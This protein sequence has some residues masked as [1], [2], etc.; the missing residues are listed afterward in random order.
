MITVQARAGRSLALE[1]YG[2]P[3]G[4]PVMWFHGIPSSRVGAR[5]LHQQALSRDVAL[6]VPDRPGYG[7]SDPDP[8]RRV[9]DWP[10]DVCT[11]ADALQLQR[12]S[13][14]GVSG[15]FQ[16]VLATA[17]A[18]PE[19]IDRAGVVSAMGPLR[20]PGAL[21]GIDRRMRLL[22]ELGLRQ[23]RVA[24][25]WFSS[26]GRSDPQ[27]V[28]RRQLRLLDSTDRDILSH[29]LQTSAR[30]DDLR[31]ASHQ[32]TLASQI[33]G[34]MYVEHWD[35][36]PAD[37][38]TP[39]HLWQGALDRTHPPAMG[40]YLADSIPCSTLHVRPG[41]GGLFYLNDFGSVLD[42]LLMGPV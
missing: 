18:I 35:F 28:V 13:L 15:G 41:V 32:N 24:R 39:F 5:V 20:A 38:K 12:F 21:V 23:P 37:L 6:I 25:L 16:Y 22:Y 36:Q 30:V 26:I 2:A 4:T 31:E 11:I 7:R 29:P 10:N 27:R 17:L 1:I 19:R 14:L 8:D 33:E 42:D 9:T 34:Q 3:H 40:R